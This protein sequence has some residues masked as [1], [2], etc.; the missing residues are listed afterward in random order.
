MCQ[1]ENNSSVLI[2]LNFS[3]NLRKRSSFLNRLKFFS[4]TLHT[5]SPNHGLCGTAI[6]TTN[7]KTK[8]WTK[9]KCFS[10]S[11][12]LWFFIVH[13]TCTL[14]LNNNNKCFAGGISDEFCMRFSFWRAIFPLVRYTTIGQCNANEWIGSRLQTNVEKEWFV[15]AI[16]WSPRSIS[17]I[18]SGDSITRCDLNDVLF[19]FNADQKQLPSHFFSTICRCI[20]VKMQWGSVYTIASGDNLHICLCKSF[21]VYHNRVQN[22]KLNGNLVV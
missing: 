12:F 15:V 8:W 19:H 20:L 7:I 4:C 14:Q 17:I 3:S 6:M 10:Q 16:G 5:R 13:C 21:N 2:D 9:T 11:V 22:M 18:S 1:T